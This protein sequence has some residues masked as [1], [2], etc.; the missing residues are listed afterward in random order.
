MGLADAM[1]YMPLLPDAVLEHF[2]PAFGGA[3]ARRITSM[4]VQEEG[5]LKSVDAT[6]WFDCQEVDGELFVNKCAY[7]L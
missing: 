4:I 5:Q 3:T 2:Y 7:H 1:R 6:W